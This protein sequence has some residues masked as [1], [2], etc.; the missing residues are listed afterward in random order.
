MVCFRDATR[1]RMNG[2]ETRLRRLELES[3][4]NS[5]RLNLLRGGR[6]SISVSHQDVG[7]GHAGLMHGTVNSET[8]TLN[9]PVKELK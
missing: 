7:S 5:A 2:Q 9:R 3:S 8:F 1:T 6:Y 4:A